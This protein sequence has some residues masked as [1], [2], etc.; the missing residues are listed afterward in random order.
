MGER[1]LFHGATSIFCSIHR[2]EVWVKGF[3]L[4]VPHEEY[5][6]S[7]STFNDGIFRAPYYLHFQ[8]H[9]LLHY[10]YTHLHGCTYDV[11]LSRLETHDFPCSFPS[12]F[13]VRGTSSH[14]WVKI[15][16]IEVNYC[17]KQ[18][19]LSFHYDIRIHECIDEMGSFLVSLV[20][21]LGAASNIGDLVTTSEDDC[22]Q[23]S[24]EASMVI[25]L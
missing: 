5:E 9:P 25:P 12:P 2:N 15:Y 18:H 1:F 21:I 16:M 23:S 8:Q 20:S 19:N 17:W 10:D 11:H 3:F 22:N 4:M 24:A 7:I 6:N 14:T 13:D